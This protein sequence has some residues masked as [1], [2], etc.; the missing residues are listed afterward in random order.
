MRREFLTLLGA[1]LMTV[2][3]GAQDH[4]FGL[5]D[6]QQDDLALARRLAALDGPV[7]TFKFGG[8]TYFVEHHRD[9]SFEGYVGYRL[10]NLAG[11]EAPDS[12]K[13]AYVTRCMDGYWSEGCES[14]EPVRGAFHVV[15]PEEY[16]RVVDVQLGPTEGFVLAPSLH[17]VPL[18]VSRSYSEP[19]GKGKRSYMPFALG[20]TV[21]SHRVDGGR[22]FVNGVSVTWAVGNSDPTSNWT[23]TVQVSYV[24]VSVRVRKWLTVG[25]TLGTAEI[26]GRS[27]LRWKGF[28]TVGLQFAVWV[29]PADE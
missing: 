11:A 21:F 17:W 10:V 1:L 24:P 20:A 19:A 23:G 28:K 16:Y 2:S 14:A 5:S 22:M 15:M 9:A 26:T 18:G 13:L 25:P 7:P 6:E 4:Q 27:W 29:S 3:A 12:A 8:T